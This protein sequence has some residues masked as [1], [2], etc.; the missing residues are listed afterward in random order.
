L[1]HDLETWAD[2]IL[3]AP[4]LEALFSTDATHL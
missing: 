3:T 4:T 1:K 2:T